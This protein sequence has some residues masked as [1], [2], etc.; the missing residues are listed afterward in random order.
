MCTTTSSSDPGG[1]CSDLRAPLI[2]S[3]KKPAGENESEKLCI[4]DMLQKYCGEFG[5]WQLRHFLLTSLAWALEAFHTM[6]MIFADREP[7]WRCL[8]GASGCDS[9]ARSVCGLVPGSW[10]W[11]GGPWTS[12][13][14]EWG[15]VCEEK[16]KVG[17]AQALFFG[18]CMIGQLSYSFSRSSF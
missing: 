16:Y 11:S 17:L 1:R 7:G 9:T 14:A 3:V 18:G 15:L 2:T 10:E 8:E 12:T 5:P 6:V 4:D 13:V